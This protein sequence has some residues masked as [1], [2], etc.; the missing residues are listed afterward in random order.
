VLGSDQEFAREGRFGGAASQRFLGGEAHKVGIVVLLRHMREDQVPRDGVEAI[1]VAKIF[2][3][4]M[5]GKMP[6]AT[7]DALLH[8]PRVRAN[9]QHIQIVIGFKDQAIGPA[10]MHF[11]Q[12]RHVAEIRNDGHLCAIRS[13]R[14]TNGIGGVVRNRKRV[15]VDIANRE[16]LARL[17]GFDSP[18]P[19]AKRLR[20][21]A[22]HRIHGRLGDVQ[23]RFPNAKHLRQSVAMIGV[24]VSD[25]D[26]VNV[27][28]GSFDGREA[29][30]RLAFAESGVHQE[31]GSPGLEQRD[32]ARAAR[33]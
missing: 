10:Q 1:R 19:L 24:F 33:R 16:V 15:N 8:Q 31:S 4:G 28:D 30:K 32:V 25:E 23:R 6:G 12:L 13:E 27:L 14:K 18:E 5:I 2:T 26:A 20:E 17:D 29:P 9:L 3:Y 11:H 22:L 7:Q 21:D